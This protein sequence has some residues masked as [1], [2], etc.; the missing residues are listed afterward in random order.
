MKAGSQER[1]KRAR[2]ARTGAREGFFQHPQAIVESP[3]IGARTRVW[4]FAHILPG[5]VVGADCNICDHVF[6]ENDVRLGDRVTIK[7]G[8]QVWDGVTLEDDVFVGPNA[9]FS[10]DAFP[11]SRQ[12]PS[13]FARTTVR[14]GASIGA[15]ATLLPGITVGHGAM[16]GAG[17]VVTRDVPPNAI[18]V[19]NPAFIKGYVNSGELAPVEGVSSRRADA[20]PGPGRVKGVDVCD[21]TLAADLRGKLVVG[22]VGKGLPFQPRRF[23]T[24]FGVPN[25]EVRGQHAHR[26]LHQFLV[27]LTGECSLVVDDGKNREEIVLNTP[28]IGVHL[29]PMVWGIQY[30]FSPD[31]VLLVLASD[32]YDPRDYIRNYEEYQALKGP[33]KRA[34]GR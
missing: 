21:L 20:R 5:A 9:T 16:V 27:C 25:R 12:R 7:C 24:V 18:V 29:K 2:T 15:N 17:A 30:K 31:A 22:E 4:A 11:R 14:S 13:E 1:G 6:L 3:R 23:F 19:G 33:K 8:V 26:K 32:K 34:R 28:R 10:N